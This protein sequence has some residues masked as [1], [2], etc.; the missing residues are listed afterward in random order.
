M[1]DKISL[2]CNNY[3]MKL[4]VKKT[5]VMILKKGSEKENTKIKVDGEYLEEISHYKYLGSKIDE[6]CSCLAEVRVRICT[7]RAAFWDCKEFL[8]REMS[9][10]L[11][12]NYLT[13]ILRQ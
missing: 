10:D 7:A 8:R 11:K 12:I 9:I 1:M 4:N 6:N 2:A 5:K 13:V 3:G